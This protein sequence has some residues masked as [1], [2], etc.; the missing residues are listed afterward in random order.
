MV[1]YKIIYFSI[2][3][4][5]LFIGCSNSESSEIINL[6]TAKRIVQNYY[7]SSNYEKDCKAIIDRAIEHINRL[8][9]PDKPTVI[10]DIDETSLANY[11]HIKEI[12]FG[13]YYDI[14]LRWLKQAD[15]VAI[16][17][18]KRFY[19][20]LIAR[21]IRIVFLTGRND[22]SYE[23]TLKN[24]AEQGYTNFD[25]VIVRNM[26][27]RNLSASEF[28]LDKRKELTQR[29]FNIIANIGDQAS[30]FYG[31]YSG[32]VIKLPNFLYLID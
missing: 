31:G 2:L 11:E 25:S 29:G 13:Y 10:F 19:D 6:G 30:D 27:E 16:P 15:A 20:Y 1:K 17:Q 4:S 3:L 9:L 28:K 12:D 23:A 18:T 14:W 22:D 5:I 7:E 8:E 26:N 32:F 21:N 24:L